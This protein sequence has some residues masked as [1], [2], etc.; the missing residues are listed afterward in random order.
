MVKP[1]ING[2]FPIYRIYGKRKFTRVHSFPFS[3]NVLNAIQNKYKETHDLKIIPVINLVGNKEY[4]VYKAEK[5][6]EE[7]T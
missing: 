2:K 1:W 7:I 5:K 3:I 4:V 6:G